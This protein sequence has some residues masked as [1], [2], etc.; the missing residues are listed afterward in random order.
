MRATFLKDT[1]SAL[2]YGIAILQTPP[3]PAQEPIVR[4]PVANKNDAKAPDDGAD[5]APDVRPS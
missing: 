3:L 5:R 2:G 4:E 1:V